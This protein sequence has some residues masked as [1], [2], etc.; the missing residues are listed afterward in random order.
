MTT[1]LDSVAGNAPDNAEAATVRTARK[2]INAAH[3]SGNITDEQHAE[4]IRKLLMNGTTLAASP[5]IQAERKR[6]GWLR[7]LFV[8]FGVLFLLTVAIIVMVSLGVHFLPTQG[9]TSAWKYAV[10]QNYGLKSQDR[11]GAFV[12]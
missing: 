6:E 11:D 5:A 1:G 3:G 8:G 10:Q 7:R 2:A 4:A 12:L 9:P